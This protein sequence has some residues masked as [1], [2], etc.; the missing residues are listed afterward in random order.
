MP[1]AASGDNAATAMKSVV[2][3]P[4]AYDW[5]GDVPLQPAVGAD[6]RLRDARPRLHP[7]SQLRRRRE[8]ARHLRRPDREDPLPPGAR[9]HR[10][11]AAA[12]VRV[13]RPGLPAGAGELLGLQ[14]VSFFAPHQ[15]YSSRQ[16]PLGPVDEF[17]DMVKALHRAGI[18]VILDVVFNHTAEGDHDG[19]TLCFRGLDNRAYYILEPTARATQLHRLRQ[20]AQRQPPDRPPHDRGQPAVL[21]RGRCTWTGSGST[22]RRSWRATRGRTC[23]RTRRCCGTS[24]RTRC[25]RAR[26]SSPRRGTRPA[27][28]RW[29]ASSGTAGRSGTA[30]SATTSGASSAASAA[31]CVRFAD[32]LIG[33]PEIYGHKEREPEQSVNFV[34]C[35]DGFTLNDLVSY[36]RKHNEANGEGNRD[37]ADDN[38]SWNCGVEGPTDD[39][40]DRAAAQPA[41]E[42]LPDRHAALARRAHDPDGRRGA[43]H[44]GRQQQR[45]LPGQRDELVRLDAASRSTRTC[46]AS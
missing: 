40:A 43:A 23:C 8:D 17:R 19:P 11:R 29:A 37:G 1:P 4:S 16:D 25:W 24:S 32:R 22:W 14:P 41:G 2:V 45:L 13:R 39:P 18:E 6:H 46:T 26:S 21:G 42:E 10:G 27:C 12:G 36:N 44:P 9:R 28:T 5:E 20:H 33:S 38:R 15:A 3:D 35:H 7:P 34:T 30:G 31:R